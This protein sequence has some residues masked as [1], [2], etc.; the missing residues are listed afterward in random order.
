MFK[1]YSVGQKVEAKC[2]KV[3]AHERQAWFDAEVVAVK[4]EKGL[5][6]YVVRFSGYVM[7]FGVTMY[8]YCF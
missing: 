2:Q 5:H 1:R 7:Q 8:S 4:Q 6:F 3:G